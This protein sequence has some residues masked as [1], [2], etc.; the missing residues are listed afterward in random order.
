MERETRIVSVSC[1]DEKHDLS[2]LKKADRS[3]IISQVKNWITS[4]V[5]C[6]EN[7]AEYLKSFAL[8]TDFKNLPDIKE[9]LGECHSYIMYT[10]IAITWVVKKEKLLLYNRLT[11]GNFDQCASLSAEHETASMNW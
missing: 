5:N 8:F 1:G 3:E 4:W 2:E 6:C 9:Q 11:A 10:Y 7:E